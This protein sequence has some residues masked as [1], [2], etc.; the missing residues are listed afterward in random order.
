MYPYSVLIAI[1]INQDG[2]REILGMKIG[3][4]ESE[5]SWSEFFTCL[6]IRGLKG[7]DFVVSDDHNGLV[8]AV[9]GV[10]KEQHASGARLISH[11]TF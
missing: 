5:E 1:G 10:F 11:A 8:N 7:V 6:K 3:N 9:A 2:Y 4:S